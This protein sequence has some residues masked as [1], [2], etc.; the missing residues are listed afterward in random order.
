MIYIE[1]P[2][3]LAACGRWLCSAVVMPGSGLQWLCLDVAMRGPTMY[4][5]LHSRVALL[6][7]SVDILTYKF[8][9][10]YLKNKG[11]MFCAFTI[12][13]NRTHPNLH[14]V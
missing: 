7:N 13:L 4:H 2:F 1:R 6:K 9:H 12:C 3:L 10:V 5:G 14:Y 11:T 8:G